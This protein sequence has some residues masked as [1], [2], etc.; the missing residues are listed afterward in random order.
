MRLYDSQPYLSSHASSLLPW[1]FLTAVAWS[2]AA[3]AQIRFEEVAGSGVDFVHSAGRSDS[4]YVPEIMGAGAGWLDYDGDGRWD[5]YLVDGGAVPGAPPVAVSSDGTNSLYRNGPDGFGLADDA[6]ASAQGYGMGVAASDYDNDGWVDLFVTNFGVDV[7][8]RNNGDGTFTDVSHLLPQEARWGASAAWGDVDADGWIDLYI[9]NYFDYPIDSVPLCNNL[10]KGIRQY[11]PPQR[12][13]GASDWLLRNQSG[14]GFDDVTVSAGMHNAA[15]GKGLAVAIADINGDDLVDVYVAND[16]TANFLYVNRGDLTFEEEGLISGTGLNDLGQPQSGMGVDIGDLDGSSSYEI[17][18]TNFLLEP[19]NIYSQIAEG[20][21]MDSSFLWGIGEATLDTL[22][23]GIA[24][25]DADS[26]GDLDVVVANGHILDDHAFFEQPN[27]LFQNFS[28]DARASGQEPRPLLRPADATND[29][30]SVPRVSRGLAVADFDDDGRPDLVVSNN[31]QP[32]Q[33]FRN[34]SGGENRLVI[35][36][37]GVAGNRDGVGAAVTVVPAG[38]EAGARTAPVLSGSSYLSRNSGDLHFGLGNATH[39]RVEV[40]WANGTSV[41]LDRVRAGQTLLVQ[42][43]RG[44]IGA[45]PHR[46]RR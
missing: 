1:L 21:F 15:Q 27:Q 33:L 41:Q 12:L 40:R 45:R 24:F 28:A 20:L 2:G 16:S 23:F 13:N 18:V 19:V 10:D 25:I 26:D 38:D 5:L 11:C 9:T 8:L 36:V 14:V 32:A 46:D 22:G 31:N 17:G 44:L 3:E 30:L 7:L 37:R 39:A 42:D 34:M 6:G 29:R 43:G 4:K 35:R